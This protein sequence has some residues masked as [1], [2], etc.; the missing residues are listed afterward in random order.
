MK[1]EGGRELAQLATNTKFNVHSEFQP[2]KMMVKA[3][4]ER[5]RLERNNG[6][7]H[8]ETS[9]VFVLSRHPDKACS[10]IFADVYCGAVLAVN[11]D[12]GENGRRKGACPTCNEHKVQMSI[13]NFSQSR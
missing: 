5:C 8:S 10:A 11:G 3:S 1:M 12:S 4:S 2:N 13:R 9:C 7:L 6:L